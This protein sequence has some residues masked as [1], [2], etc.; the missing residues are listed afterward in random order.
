MAIHPDAGKPV[1]KENL[2]DV[3]ELISMYYETQ[4]DVSNPDEKQ[5]KC[6]TNKPQNLPQS[7]LKVLITPSN[8]SPESQR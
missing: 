6:V 5:Q 8:A 2:T 3:A 7:A 1:K 4:P